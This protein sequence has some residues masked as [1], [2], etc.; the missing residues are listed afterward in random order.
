M[1][2]AKI[3]W[4]PLYLAV[5]FLVVVFFIGGI[6]WVIYLAIRYIGALVLVLLPSFIIRSSGGVTQETVR[7]ATAADPIRISIEPSQTKNVPI[8]ER[9][10]KD[11]ES[12]Q[13]EDDDELWLST[14]SCRNG[15]YVYFMYLRAC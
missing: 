7:S 5:A 15:Q 9:N 12:H 2:K 1:C 11:E 6:D 3:P 10:P 14:A 8:A 13:E 4:Y